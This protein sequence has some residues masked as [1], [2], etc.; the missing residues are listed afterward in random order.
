[1]QPSSV[2]LLSVLLVLP[3]AAQDGTQRDVDRVTIIMEFEQQPSPICADA[4][5]K[6]VESIMRPCGVGWEW[7]LLD[8]SVSKEAFS[9]LAVVRFRG[10]CQSIAVLP[11]MDDKVSLG[12]THVSEG[13]VL[14]FCEVDCDRVRRFIRRETGHQTPTDRDRSL[15]RALGRVLAHELYHVFAATKQHSRHGVA[16]ALLSARELVNDRLV[17]EGHEP[18]MIRRRILPAESVILSGAGGR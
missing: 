6:E 9:H 5:R 14:P 16:K 10:A 7:R 13:E 4:M 3:A 8:D 15:G 1:M 17:F 12:M 18:E 11:S 2:F